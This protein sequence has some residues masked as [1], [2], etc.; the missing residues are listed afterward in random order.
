MSRET[1]HP[2]PHSSEAPH[3]AAWWS[4]LD[5][6]TR[7]TQL[8]LSRIAAF[9]DLPGYEVRERLSRGGQGAIYAAVDVT[10]REAVAIKVLPHGLFGS[11]SARR[12]FEREIEI[13]GEL[14]HP[15]IVRVLKSGRTSGGLP[16]FVMPRIAGLPYD[17]WAEL[18]R[19]GD[20][21]AIVALHAQLCEAIH[22]AHE[23]GV[24]HRDLKPSNVLID[25]ADQPNVL[26]FGLAKALDGP[27][28][29]ASAATTTMTMEHQFV[30]SMPWTSPE[31]LSGGADAIDV[32]SDVYA[33]GVMLF[34]ALTGEFPYVVEGSL[35]AIVNNIIN[36]V[37][38]PVSARNAA[39]TGA[40][41]AIVLKALAKSPQARYG[42]A[43]DFALD[44]R[45]F[46]DGGSSRARREQ[47][48]AGLQRNIRRYQAIAGVSAALLALSA[49]LFVRAN[50]S[51][52]RAEREAA[53]SVAAAK[54]L[55]DLFDAVNPTGDG[56]SVTVADVLARASE[57][58]PVEF[59]NEPQIA[60]GLHFMLGNAY[61]RLGLPENERQ[62]F[63]SY[64]LRRAAL[65]E[66]HPETLDAAFYVAR[67][68]L[69]PLTRRLEL[70]ERVRSHRTRRL[71]ALHSDV[72]AVRRDHAILMLEF[73]DIRACLAASD[74]LLDDVSAGLTSNDRVLHNIV[75]L[76]ID[77]ELH[78]G[79]LRGAMEWA[80]RLETLVRDHPD[81]DYE[82]RIASYQYRGEVAI[83]QQRFN[84]AEAEL[85]AARTLRQRVFPLDHISSIGLNSDLALCRIGQGR[86][87]EA[88]RLLHSYSASQASR[89]R[90]LTGRYRFRFVRAMHRLHMARGEISDAIGLLRQ[91]LEQRASITGGRSGAE[92]LVRCDLLT[93]LVEAHLWN[94]AISVGDTLLRDFEAQP[95][96]RHR[97]AR[98]MLDYAT[99]LRARGAI[100][101]ADRR[102]ALACDAL[103]QELGPDHSWTRRASALCE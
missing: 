31:Q 74:D 65:G 47:T 67:T 51:R 81:P 12:R 87:A 90:A 43:K 75:G 15:Q 8:H 101:A 2:P 36:I 40:L 99:C 77:N 7:E 73:G 94:E 103:L 57:R 60:A 29:L 48:L 3:G 85:E 91:W 33:L 62:Y 80:D 95:V 50:V 97:R 24:I 64:E 55:E 68:E 20:L 53:K 26:D 49:M 4:D 30:G 72:I 23:R 83:V 22:F 28:A 84:D 54:F 88:E 56:L 38:Q 45:Q 10:T 61:G 9:G 89:E 25:A 17:R 79:D 59:A 19:A 21:R 98:V 96:A 6:L 93:A 27:G 46:L 16:Y 66:N 70:V 41:D 34:Q 92:Q 52:G 42:S 14:R 35:T 1:T 11:E 71:P 32:R 13:V 18:R 5:S 86:L 100:E 78:Y 37:P 63:R 39:V 76:K 82:Y 44:L 69:L 58:I 102:V